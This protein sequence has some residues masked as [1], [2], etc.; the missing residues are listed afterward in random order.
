MA[1]VLSFTQPWASLVCLGEKKIETR[2]WKTS[3][4]GPLLI[5]ASKGYPGWAK[6]AAKEEPFYSSLRPNGVYSYPELACGKIIGSCV[7][8]DCIPT[9][10]VKDLSEKEEEFGDYA[11]GRFAWILEDGQ[12]LP[13]PVAVKGA[14]GLWDTLPHG[15]W[16]ECGHV[17]GH[18]GVDF[19]HRCATG[20]SG[21]CT[22]GGCMEFR[23]KQ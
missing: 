19:P 7:L 10:G 3:Y 17:S 4:R 6:N 1:K 12:F 21:G 23:R 13:Q 22:N 2:S 20:G 14:L 5:H 16:C 18:H 9:S 11:D 15:V 8:K